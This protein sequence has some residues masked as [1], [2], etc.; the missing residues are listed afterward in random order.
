[1]Q[2]TKE[3]KSDEIRACVVYSLLHLIVSI[4]SSKLFL[5]GGRSAVALVECLTPDKGDAGSSLTGV[6]ALCP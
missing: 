4:A 6:T 3:K 5:R 1:M 2:T